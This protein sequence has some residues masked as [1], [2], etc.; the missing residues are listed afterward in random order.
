MIVEICCIPQLRSLE[1]LGFLRKRNVRITPQCECYHTR[2]EHMIESQM[3]YARAGSIKFA[4]QNNS[5]AIVPIHHPRV[6]LVY[7]KNNAPWTAREH[8]TKER[9]HVKITTVMMTIPPFMQLIKLIDMCT[10]YVT[11]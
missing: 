3:Y 8:I 11:N 7:H 10:I 4:H 6:P 2:D 5:V 9:K 1:G